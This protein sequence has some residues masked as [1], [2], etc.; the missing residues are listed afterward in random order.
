M[1]PIDFVVFDG[2]SEP[3]MPAYRVAEAM[4][5]DIKIHAS[6]GEYE[7]LSYYYS[8]GY[9]VLDVQRKQEGD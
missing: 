9:L 3:N 7:I 6:D 5:N 2:D 8:D 1:K 4:N